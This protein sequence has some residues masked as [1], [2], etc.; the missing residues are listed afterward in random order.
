M[1]LMHASTVVTSS[2][3][4]PVSSRKRSSRSIDSLVPNA[5]AAGGGSAALADDMVEVIFRAMD[6]VKRAFADL[7][8]REKRQ[9]M[10]ASDVDLLTR[11]AAT[12]A[13]RHADEL[14]QARVRGVE[15]LKKLT[16]AA[17]GFLDGRQVARLLGMTPAGVH[18]R[19]KSRQLLG[20]PRGKRGIG[21]PALQFDGAAVV[22]DLPLVLR[23]LDD[24]GLDPWAQLRFLAGKN[25]RLNGRAP[26]DALKSGELEKVLAAARA[27]GEHGAA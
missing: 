22:R 2:T 20:V 3:E 7:D 15:A 11:L 6:A 4:V 1:E 9:L 5:A 19:L 25:T 24:S 10:D 14:A 12:T 26:V 18:K 16:D 21:Y 27:F 23:V 8:V 13:E 17:G